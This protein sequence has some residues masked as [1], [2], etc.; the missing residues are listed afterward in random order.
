MLIKRKI[1]YIFPKSVLPLITR[2]LYL[3]YLTV[4]LDQVRLSKVRREPR[5]LKRERIGT[6]IIAA[7]E[8]ETDL[9]HLHSFESDLLF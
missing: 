3:T 9:A 1:L 7:R 8:A 5:E 6:A 4:D 2:E